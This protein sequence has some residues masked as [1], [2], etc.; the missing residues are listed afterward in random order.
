MAIE[1]INGKDLKHNKLLN[2]IVY[3][4]PGAGKTTFCATSPKP[5]IIDVE[6]GTV[7]IM[8]TDIDI[9]KANTDEDVKEAVTYAIKNGYKTICIDSLT[10]YLEILM[11]SILAKEIKTKPQIQHWGEL[12]NQIKKKIWYL[13]NCG[14]NSIFV[15]LEKE[16]EEDGQLVKRPNLNGQLV[17]AIPAI[18]DVVGYLK[19][20]TNKERVLAVN[21]TDR[22][23]AKHRAPK[24]N[25]IEED[26][27]PDFKILANKIYGEVNHATAIS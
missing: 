20:N 24:E 26:I 21:P 12:V 6:G 3:G 17:Q 18:V 4:A 5:L 22:Y 13:Q 10:R 8:G 27:D 9:V 14:L 16:I 11:D 25:R 7:S 2:V 23:Y 1:I 19:I 15:C